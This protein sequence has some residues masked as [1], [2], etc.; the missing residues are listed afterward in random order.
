LEL[1][2]EVLDVNHKEIKRLKLEA[3]E[4]LAITVASI[5]TARKNKSK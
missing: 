5:K 4:L 2:L 3:Q 1:F